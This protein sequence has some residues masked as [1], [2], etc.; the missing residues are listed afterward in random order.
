MNLK[1]PQKRNHT[2]S[3]KKT[4]KQETEET[5]QEQNPEIRD[6]LLKHWSS[7]RSYTRLGPV[8]DFYFLL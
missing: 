5:L 4:N 6:F 2:I 1:T 3:K 7:I 8:Q